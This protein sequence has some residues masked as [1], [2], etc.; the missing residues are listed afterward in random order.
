MVVTMSSVGID[1]SLLQAARSS[2]ARK[3]MVIPE[4]IR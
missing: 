3:K 4:R 2:E 1:E